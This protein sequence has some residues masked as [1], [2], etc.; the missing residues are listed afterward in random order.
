MSINEPENNNLLGQNPQSNEKERDIY[1]VILR[2]SEE[3]V[4]FNQLKFLSEISP[5]IVYNKSIE[6]GKGSYLEYIVFK[7][8][9]KI[10]DKDKNKKNQKLEYIIDEDTYDILFSVKENTFV[11]ETELKKGNKFI[12]NIVKETIDQNIPL[13]NKLDIFL[14][15]LKKNKEDDKIELLYKETVDLYEKKKIWSFNILIS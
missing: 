13:Y 9:I 14:E 1:F 4:N 10:K 2:P 6:K 8:N 3:K 7:L 5:K 15:A 12:D 11:Y